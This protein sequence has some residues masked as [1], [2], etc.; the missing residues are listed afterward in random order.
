VHLPIN[1]VQAATC[2]AGISRCPDPALES[3]NLTAGES[4]DFIDGA[5]R[6]TSPFFKT[7]GSMA[8]HTIPLGKYKEQITFPPSRHHLLMPAL[9]G[10]LAFGN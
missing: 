5:V 1:P 2:A 7:S 6:T 4:I 9:F 3:R 8:T 10:V